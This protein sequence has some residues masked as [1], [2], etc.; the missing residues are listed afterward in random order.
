MEFYWEDSNIKR[1]KIEGHISTLLDFRERLLDQTKEGKFN[2]PE[3]FVNLVSDLKIMEDVEKVI[4]QKKTESL[5]YIFLVGIGG[6]NLGAKAVYDSRFGFFDVLEPERFPKIIF[7]DTIN[8]EFINKVEDLLERCISSSEEIAVVFASKSGKTYE[9]LSN[10]EFLLAKLSEKLGR[11]QVNSRSIVITEGRSPLDDFA[12]NNELTT[13]YVPPSVSGRYSVFS[14]VGLLPLGLSGIDIKSLRDGSLAGREMCLRGRMDNPALVS[15]SVCF[16]LLEMN[17]INIDNHFF[18]TPQLETLGKWWRQLIAESLGKSKTRKGED[19][20]KYITPMVSIGSNDLHSMFQ[21]FVG[22]SRDKITTFVWSRE[23]EQ[24]DYEGGGMS[25]D[26]DLLSKGLE[27]N[28]AQK[29][30]LEA[31]KQVY[32]DEKIPFMEVVLSEISEYALGEFMQFKMMESVY[33]AELLDVNAFDQ[34]EVE[35]YKSKVN[36]LIS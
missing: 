14:A 27:I 21:L 25:D 12:S 13:L 8:Q 16:E 1:E 24:V 3:S 19:L 10:A 9:T 36:H 23:R 35:K 32:K 4:E 11:E 17:G 29:A 34:P 18:F 15:A 7:L 33:L 30:L 5:K 20:Q 28:K 26:E 2:L 31:T 6:S 22:G